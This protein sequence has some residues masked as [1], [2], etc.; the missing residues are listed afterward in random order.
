M[1]FERQLDLASGIPGIRYFAELSRAERHAGIAEARVVHQV[2]E[3]AAQLHMAAFEKIRF[4]P[5]STS[6]E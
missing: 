4:I 6:R 3:L 1:H 2:E 5:D